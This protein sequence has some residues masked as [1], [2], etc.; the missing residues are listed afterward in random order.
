[1]NTYKR[2]VAVA[3]FLSVVCAFPA[4]V[5]GGPW[6]V[7]DRSGTCT[8][9]DPNP[10]YVCTPG[11]FQFL[12]TEYYPQYQSFV[13]NLK[14]QCGYVADMS[15]YLPGWGGGGYTP[16]PLDI[17][18]EYDYNTKWA[19]ETISQNGKILLEGNFQCAQNPW[20]NGAYQSGC[21]GK[22]IN[23]STK[24]PANFIHPPYPK[25]AQYMPSELLVALHDWE[26]NKD[27]PDPLANWDPNAPPPG[28]SVLKITSPAPYASIDEHAPSFTLALEGLPHVPPGVL[29]KKILMRWQYLQE[30]PEGY[31][32]DIYFPKGSYDWVP[33]DGP[34]AALSTSFPLTVP[35][36]PGYFAGK[37]GRYRVQVKLESE[38]WWSPWRSFWI[39]KKPA[40]YNNIDKEMAIES[41]ANQTQMKKLSLQMKRG[42]AKAEGTGASATQVA[43]GMKFKKA[44][45]VVETLAYKPAPATPGKMIDL[46]ITFKNKGLAES[47]PDLK[48][49]VTCTVKSGGP[50]CAVASCT[51]SINKAIPAGKTHS[52]TLAGATPAVAGTYEVT[53]K[54][55]GGSADSGMTITINVGLKIKPTDKLRIKTQ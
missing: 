39:G 55:E 5:Q 6:G 9:C 4:W 26:K 36:E 15:K 13:I 41:K 25:S 51:R 47:S 42:I 16:V 30:I 45:V 50:A 37:P 33:F 28:Y 54:P 2:Y 19:K 21:T 34:P 48:Y 20:T 49:S 43:T 8:D 24:Q 12:G 38:T 32:G 1:M 7:L 22:Y 3:I 53:V 17:R 18:G 11:S 35:V 29:G 40:I 14:G 10:G 27:K 44:N 23:F 52:V 31:H 46:I